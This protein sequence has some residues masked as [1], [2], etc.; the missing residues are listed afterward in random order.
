MLCPY[1]KI[2]EN[3]YENPVFPSLKGT[4]E[5]FGKCDEFDC[6]AYYE[7]VIF[8]SDDC[9]QHCRFVEKSTE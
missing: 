2:T 5:K 8:D 6:P 4:Q 1:K 7:E 9:V 3:I